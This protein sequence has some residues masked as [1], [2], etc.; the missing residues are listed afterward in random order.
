[1]PGQSPERLRALDKQAQAAGFRNYAEL[2][3]WSRQ[4]E[5]KTGGTVAAPPSS[6]G[7]VSGAY[8]NAMS[9][10]PK[11]IFQRIADLLGGNQ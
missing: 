5:R 7:G 10:H 8:S 4:R 9:W 1:M 2:E 3:A 11:I 6:D